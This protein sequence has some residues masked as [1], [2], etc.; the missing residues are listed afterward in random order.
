MKKVKSHQRINE[1]I[2]APLEKPTLKWLAARM[3]AWATPDILTWVGIIGSI[4][5]FLSYALSFYDKNFLWLASFGFFLN[6]FGDSLDGTLAR[7]RKIERP[8][9]GYFV[10]HSVDA[11]GTVLIFLGIGLSPYVQFEFACLALIGYLS[12]SIHVYLYTSVK[13]VFQISFAKLGPTEIRLIAIIANTIVYFVG[14]PIL[15]L[16]FGEFTF[17]NLVVLAVSVILFVTFII[18]TIIRST[19]LSRLDR[20][21]K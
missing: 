10:D 5:I 19:E 18:Q 16:S 9:Y 2:T 15:R 17:Y 21:D 7:H 11:I 20:A 14:N 13:G 12:L 6:W 4:L 3:P 1:T 8:I